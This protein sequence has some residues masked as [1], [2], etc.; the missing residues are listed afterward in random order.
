[1][2]AN[3]NEKFNFSPK[4]MED[5]QDE[6]QEQE[7]VDDAE[8]QNDDEN[9]DVEDDKDSDEEDDDKEDQD[10]E[11]DDGDNKGEDE[12]EDD[13]DEDDKED[14]DKEDE[15][16]DDEEEKDD[17]EESELKTKLKELEEYREKNVKANKAII[18]AFEAE[19]VVAEILKD[20]VNGLTI[21]Q[22]FAKYFDPSDL[23][24]EEGDPDEEDV[25]KIKE[26]RAKAKKERDDYLAKIDENRKFSEQTV[27][28][29]AKEKGL[30]KEAAKD[31][32]K[33]VDDFLIDIYDG[34]LTKEF[35][36]AMKKAFDFDAEIEAAKKAAEVK[37]RNEKIEIKKQKKAAEKDG[38]PDLSKKSDVIEKEEKPKSG[39]FKAMDHYHKR[40]IF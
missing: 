26:E 11:G 40:T 15:E 32:Y 3:G 39:F 12:S 25:K 6:E 37:A 34:K 35:F 36:T 13:E 4:A 18:E 31:F 21:R 9:Q 23:E 16:A 22:A 20:I 19:P 8:N 29:F 17:D 28:E 33:K 24:V 14:E 38:L 5:V 1:M 10:D 30:E 27:K 7:D 2:L